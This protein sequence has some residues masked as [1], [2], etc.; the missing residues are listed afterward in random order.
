MLINTKNPNENKGKVKEIQN[1]RFKRQ[2]K[3][4]ERKRKKKDKNVDETLKIIKKILD[5]NKN[6]QSFFYR[7]S[8]IDKEKSKP[9][10]EKSIAERM[11]LRRQKLDIIAKK[12]ENI[13]NELFSYYFDYLSPENMFKK[14]SDASDEK[15]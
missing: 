10:F 14:L 6:A 7:A 2:N 5:C 3:K 11:K 8:K 15:K 13:N 9:R 12:K 4:N 1:I